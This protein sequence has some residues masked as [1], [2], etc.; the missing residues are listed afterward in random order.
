MKTGGI[1]GRLVGEWEGEKKVGKDEDMGAAR[2]RQRGNSVGRE[3]QQKVRCP[4]KSIPHYVTGT[5][6]AARITPHN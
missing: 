1:K 6:L 2:K 5:D 3:L 4:G